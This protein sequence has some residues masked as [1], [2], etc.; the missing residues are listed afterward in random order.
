[1]LPGDRIAVFSLGGGI[2]IGAAAVTTDLYEFILVQR[3]R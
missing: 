2:L 1:M 3:H